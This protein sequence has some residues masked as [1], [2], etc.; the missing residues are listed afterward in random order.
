MRTPEQIKQRILCKFRSRRALWL[1]ETLSRKYGLSMTDFPLE[2]ILEVPS[3]AEAAS[4][5][6]G[7]TTWVTMWK[8]A[9]KHLPC[10]LEWQRR[11][12]PRFGEQTLPVRVGIDTLDD[13]LKWLDGA[14]A[15]E[16]YLA[17]N[18]IG[19]VAE[20]FPACA[21]EC[22]RHWAPLA[23]WSDAD[24]ERLLSALGWLSAH[25]NSGLYVRQLP[26]EGLDTKWLTAGRRR[27]TAAL[28]VKILEARGEEADPDQPFEKLCGLKDM[29]MSLVR[30]RLLDENYRRKA[31]GL[32]DITAPAE[33]LARLDIRPKYVFISENLQTGLAFPDLPRS[34]VICGQGNNLES[35]PRIPW[36]ADASS[37]IYWGDLDTYGFRILAQARRRLPNVRS[38]MMDVATLKRFREMWVKEPEQTVE[39]YLA[40]L[41]ET[42]SEAF[43]CLRDNRLG[44]NLRLEQERISWPYAVAQ[45]RAAVGLCP[46]T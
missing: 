40:D 35:L 25:R 37:C 19:T 43:L 20:R 24:F 23:E 33:E 26:I 17:E 13:V 28:L 10:R 9:E 30:V 3:E 22:C 14:T 38:V 29:P 8:W 2:Y 34:V 45:L 41:N 5:W 42:E 18:R 21:E 7:L 44:A 6:N 15:N 12:W 1:R 11:V 36:V 39:R 27:L 4:N 31:G 46:G 32:S 16:W